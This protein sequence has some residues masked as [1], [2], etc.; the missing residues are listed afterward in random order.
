MPTQARRLY[1]QFYG[2]GSIV[3]DKLNLL[4]AEL[5]AICVAQIAE[6]R[7]VSMAALQGHFIRT[8]AVEA[9]K[10]CSLIFVGWP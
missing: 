8:D 5:E 3:E 2:D 9:V 1:L 4:A 10:S 7:S 6:K